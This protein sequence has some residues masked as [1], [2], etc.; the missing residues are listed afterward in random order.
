MDPYRSALESARAEAKRLAARVA[1]LEAEKTREKTEKAKTEKPYSPWKNLG[2]CFLEPTGYMT[3]QMGAFF[4]GFG[5]TY[6]AGLVFFS[7]VI[8]RILIMFSNKLKQESP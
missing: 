4:A 3:I 1:E 6:I 7:Y 5:K 2:A 8:G